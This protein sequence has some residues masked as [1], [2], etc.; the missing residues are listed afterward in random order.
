MTPFAPP[1]ACYESGCPRTVTRGTYCDAH[2][3]VRVATTPK[4]KAL[5]PSK[6]GY[7]HRW[8]RVRLAYITANP[9]CV[10]CER[11]GL[12]TQASQVDHIVPLRNG[13][14]RLDPANLQSLC[15]SHHSRKTR[16]ESH[17]NS[18]GR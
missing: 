5:A 16:R 13:G 3:P 1:T 17:G 9:L 7:D 6:R 11:E 18:T 2:K 14:A 15:A 4:A 12:V 8:V 10:T